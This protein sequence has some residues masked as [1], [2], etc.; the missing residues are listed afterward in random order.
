MRRWLVAVILGLAAEG[1][2]GQRGAELEPLGAEP[3][4]AEKAAFYERVA[5]VASPAVLD[6]LASAVALE[7]GEAQRF[8]LE[9]IVGRYVEID[10]AGA[11]RLAGPLL[12]AG[13]DDLVQRIYAR[14]GERDV[15]AALE[16]LSRTDNEVEERIA[17]NA[18]LEAL[19]GDLRALEL[20]G[21]ALHGIDAD[22]FRASAIARIGRA[23]PREGFAAALQLLDP[24]ARASTAASI[25]ASWMESAPNEALEALSRVSDPAVRARLNDVALGVLRTADSIVAFLD[26]LDEAERRQALSNG[27]L[28]RLARIDP[29]AAADIVAGMAAGEDRR[30]LEMQV[31]MAFA[32]SDPA[33]ALAWARRISPEDHRLAVQI[34]RVVASDEPVRALDL[35]DSLEEPARSQG[36]GAVVGVGGKDRPYRA[37]ADRVLRLPEDRT[38]VTAVDSLLNVWTMDPGNAPQAVEW[39]LANANAVPPHSFQRLAY[40]LA[41]TDP[42]AAERYFDRVPSAARAGWL[43]AVAAS[44]AA[45]DPQQALAFVERYRGDAG[46]DGAATMLAPLLARSDPAA[47]ARLL[48]SVTERSS[49]GFGAEVQIAREWSQRDP[50][51]AATWAVDLPPLQRNVIMQMVT[52][53]WASADRD[54]VRRWALGLPAGEKRD[55][56]LAAAVRA[57]GA[58]PD[59]ALMGAFSDDRARQ[60]AIMGSVVNVAMT[61][62]DAARRLLHAHVTDPRM[63][64]QAEQVIETMPRATSPSPAVAFPGFMVRDPVTGEL[65]APGSA[66]L[67]PGITPGMTPGMPPGMPPGGISPGGPPTPFIVPP[68][69]RVFAPGPPMPGVPQEIIIQ[70]EPRSRR[71]PPP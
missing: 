14:L 67:P 30:P 68:T 39:A 61:D 21:A 19:G 49:Q 11:V 46:F 66:S 37:L 45:T 6:A 3:T 58:E 4:V 36:I 57:Y 70:D 43:G 18:L 41:R 20:V 55:V 24:R 64:S 29:L 69:G 5:R 56:A 47:A 59:P 71:A 9:A 15:N 28:G 2:Y 40:L 34:L 53:A 22:A 16:A 13:A 26:T 27:V 7:P 10:A 31:G 32:Q 52:S 48:G 12:G 1:G 50:A 54:A 35:A 25:M 23:S 33:A 63:R 65:A 38:R 42:A 51:A 17:A 60:A 44:Y 62:R 8:Q